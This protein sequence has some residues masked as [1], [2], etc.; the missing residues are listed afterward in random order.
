MSD[1]GFIGVA[2][3]D[4]QRDECINGER[5]ASRR[6]GQRERRCCCWC[7]RRRCCSSCWF[8][9]LPDLNMTT[10]D[11]YRRRQKYTHCEVVF[12]LD[13]DEQTAAA[14]GIDSG[15]VNQDCLA[16][17]AFEDA[18][19]RDMRR[20][21]SN[22]AYSFVFL[23]VGALE[24]DAALR[25]CR[26][27]AWRKRP[28][29]HVAASWRLLVWPPAP[30]TRKARA[31]WWCASFVH[32]A[33]QHAGLLTH[34]RLNTLDVDDIVAEVKAHRRRIEMAVTPLQMATSITAVHERWFK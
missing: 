33:L 24:Y 10:L 28:Y 1:R 17:A 11:C 29:N 31:R 2:Y 21:F 16:Y 25:F 8:C 14:V 4:R 26:E 9:W 3:L 34:L 32:A 20:P 13:A 6:L 30:P 7:H 19:V 22:T 18:G 27:E 12:P 23:K 15:R 5:M